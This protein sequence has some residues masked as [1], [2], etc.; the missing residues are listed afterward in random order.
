MAH[1]TLI[2]HL[3]LHQLVLEMLF[4]LLFV[5]LESHNMGMLPVATTDSGFS[6]MF[7]CF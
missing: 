7:I 6:S 4:L 3:G 5:F 1:I 2:T